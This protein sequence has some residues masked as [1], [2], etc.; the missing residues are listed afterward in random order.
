[1]CSSDLLLTAAV[2]VPAEA[3]SHANDIHFLVTVTAFATAAAGVLLAAAFYVWRL[4]IPAAI[5]SLLRP[6]HTFLKRGWYF[7]EIYNWMFVKPTYGIA[8][9]ASAND[10]RIIDP[11]VHF[12]A[13]ASRQ[14][15]AGD[16]WMDRVVVDGLVNVLASA[17]WA[18]GLRL[19]A[20]Q[21]GHLRQYVMFIV[22]GTVAIFL[23]ASIMFGTMV[24]GP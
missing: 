16:A 3:A 18:T 12:F 7:D 20:I 6:A 15:A 19:R 14:L 2:T 24:A 13:W 23:L 17:T 9:L 22:V 10:R 21:T 11:I 5:A 1:M 8:A 4:V